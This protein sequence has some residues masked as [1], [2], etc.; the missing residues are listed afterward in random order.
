[1]EIDI[2]R[3]VPLNTQ[4]ENCTVGN[5]IILKRSIN[6]NLLI[7]FLQYPKSLWGE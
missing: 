1:M 2:E 3:D 5:N 7:N 4:P 6:R